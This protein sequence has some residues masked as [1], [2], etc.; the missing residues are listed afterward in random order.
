M[1]RVLPI[2]S[3]FM[4]KQ[5]NEEMELERKPGWEEKRNGIFRFFLIFEI[6]LMKDIFVL[7]FHFIKILLTHHP[8]KH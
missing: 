5:R 8:N 4:F 7:F 2:P 3:G 1:A 6:M